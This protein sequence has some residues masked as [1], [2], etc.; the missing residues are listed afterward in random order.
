MKK[1]KL[2]FILLLITLTTQFVIAND[3]YNK[4]E[5]YYK[6]YNLDS[7]EILFQ[8]A[9]EVS[10]DDQYLSGDNKMYKV[11]KIDKKTHTGYAE[12]VR[13]VSLPEIDHDIFSKIKLTLEN[14]SDISSILVQ[15]EQDDKSKRKIG[16]YATHSAESYIP[17]DGAESIDADGGI[18]QVADKLKE[19]F[20]KNGVEAIFDDT[21]H[22]PHDAGAYKRSRRTAVQLIREEQPTAIIDVHR[23]AIPAEEY[24]TKINGEPAAK[25]RLVVGRRN[26]NFKANE[27]VAIKIKAVADEMY[28]DL[29]KDV[30]YGKGD[31]NQDLIPRA[32]LV[33]MGTY[34]HTRERS[35][36]SANYL[37]EVVATA[38]FGDTFKDNKEPEI[39]S[40]D[41]K[42][43]DTTNQNKPIKSASESNKGA[44]A[45]ILGI[46]G[47]VVLGGVGYLYISK[48][49]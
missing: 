12:F 21:P 33:E 14:K 39:T 42:G 38:I 35:E 48:E 27:D 44:G 41:T 34:K 10:K 19:G 17:S 18:L 5:S 45:G 9:R 3:W 29:I 28:P 23:D 31:Y 13:D 20:E 32:M 47:L 46:V 7:N 24:L 6:I 16:I 8:T 1:N 49:K 22:D 36:K 37:S 4:E 15:A 30:F 2:F 40:K 26:Q 11:V 43:T 25:V